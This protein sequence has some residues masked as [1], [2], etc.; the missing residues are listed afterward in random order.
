MA[1]SLRCALNTGWVRNF[2]V[3]SNGSGMASSAASVS[4]TSAASRPLP[5]RDAPTS[6]ATTSRRWSRVVVSSQATWTTPPP[7][8][9][10]L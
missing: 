6:A 9:H 5:T 7:A 2:E 10:R 1:V 8:S 3:R 4:R